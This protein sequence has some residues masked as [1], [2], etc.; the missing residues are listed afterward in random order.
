MKY[1]VMECHKGYA[2]LMDEES[3]FVTAAD[4]HYE[5]GQT[6]TDPVVM[7]E[8]PAAGRITFTVG[9]FIAAAA[10]LVLFASAGMMYYSHNL[11]PHS[12]VVISAQANI[13]MEVNKKGKV[14]QLISDSESGKELLKNY[15]GKGKDKLTVANEII[16][17]ELEKGY[18]SNGDTI[19][20][21]VS[22]DDSNGY[23]T[24]K[25][26]LE[27]S[28]SDISVSVHGV[29]NDDKPEK[30][31][32]K[33]QKPEPPKPGGEAGHEKPAAD[34][35][36]PVQPPSPPAVTPP[37]HDTPPAQKPEP[38]KKSDKAD[39]TPAPPAAAEPKAPEKPG[40]NDH[41][42]AKKP[43]APAVPAK[44]DPPGEDKHSNHENLS[45]ETEINNALGLGELLPTALLPEAGQ[46]T[47]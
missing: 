22:S 38:P 23:E 15:S 14:I 32:D 3:R 46:D 9:K 43:E 12:T 24:F 4:L 20:L 34:K 1:I 26:D 6:V 30:P 17:L 27:S 21:Y 19:D 25:S 36:K 40:E 11:K 35:E 31:A 44:P 33:V 16:G 47:T 13:K 10:C 7:N 41:G 39:N 29:G 18:V 2:V 8:K 28:I 5:V 42:D 45:E 37:A